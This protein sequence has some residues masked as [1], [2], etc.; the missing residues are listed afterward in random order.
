MLPAGVLLNN[1][2][3]Y[4]FSFLSLN[5][6]GEIERINFSHPQR[7]SFLNADVETVQKW[8]EAMKTFH[9]MLYDPQYC[10]QF[11]MTPGTLPL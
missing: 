5:G 2:N 10:L 7:D 8:Y 11:K 3:I 1:N 4:I 9:D 6:D